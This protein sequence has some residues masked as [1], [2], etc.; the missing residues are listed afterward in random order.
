MEVS[1][2]QVFSVLNNHKKKKS[3]IPLLLTGSLIDYQSLQFKQVPVSIYSETGTLIT[4]WVD[5]GM[6]KIPTEVLSCVFYL[7][8]NP[9]DAKAGVEFGGTGFFVTI[10]SEKDS[11]HL[12]VYAVT[13]YHVIKSGATTIRI[14]TA[15]G[16]TDIMEFPISDW[17]YIPRGGDV[18]VCSV[19]NY[20]KD[21]DIKSIPISLFATKSIIDKKHIGIGDDIFMIG[22]FI[23][24]DGGPIN[25]PA[26]RFGNISVM[27]VLIKEMKN[28]GKDS[29]C[30]DL[31]S[32]SGFSGAPVFVYRTPGN[33]IKTSMRRGV[34]IISGG[35]MYFLGIHW[36]QFT[37][38]WTITKKG[39]SNYIKGLSG[40]TCAMPP[41]PILE[42][43][44]IQ[45]L[46]DERLR[47]DIAL[48]KKFEIY[49]YP[50]NEE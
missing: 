9:S 13:N 7:Y 29:Y 23:D 22:R 45:S 44:N 19:T 49:G 33:D 41:E 10:P 5:G 48:E 25:S 35:F 4:R 47:G 21:H 30:L 38:E 34:N 2:V 16:A 15:N 17:K 14:N 36:G 18:A 50:P 31:H 26:V 28:G 39:K 11:R 46:K 12:Y 20:Y 6:P 37:E 1:P 42:A 27:P 32:R 8:N 40:M 43:L 24:Y 3:T